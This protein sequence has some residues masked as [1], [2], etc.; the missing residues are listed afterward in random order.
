MLAKKTL[1]TVILVHF[2]LI[3][4]AGDQSFEQVVTEEYWNEVEEQDNQ[5]NDEII[6]WFNNRI[7]KVGEKLSN[8]CVCR[9]SGYIV[10]P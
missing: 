2:V 8:N 9:K 1:H 6:C 10:C 7:L 5:R 3:C 4:C